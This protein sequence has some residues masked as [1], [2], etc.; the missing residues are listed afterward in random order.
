MPL[1]VNKK[2]IKYIN[3]SGTY[4]LLPQKARP[5][6]VYYCDT[7]NSYDCNKELLDPVYPGQTLR[8][9]LTQT[10]WDSIQHIE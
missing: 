8:L 3:K 5:K 1:E 7:N 9:S 10:V 2:F 4:H 6:T